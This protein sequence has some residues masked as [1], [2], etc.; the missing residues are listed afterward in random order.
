MSPPHGVLSTKNVFSFLKTSV[1]GASRPVW[2]APAS[3]GVQQGSLNGNLVGMTE[4][5]SH[6]RSIAMLALASLKQANVW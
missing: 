1:A 4:R 6:L 5:H 2:R 3:L